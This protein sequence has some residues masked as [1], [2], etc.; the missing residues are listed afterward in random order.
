MYWREFLY[1]FVFY[2]LKKTTMAINKNK[3]PL[4]IQRRIDEI[5]SLIAPVDELPNI[6]Y[7]YVGTTWPFKIHIKKILVT[8]K[9]VTIVKGDY[10]TYLDAPKERFNANDEDYF[11]SNGIIVLKFTLSTILKAYKKALNEKTTNE[12]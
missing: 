9:F 8:G 5:N 1:T 7:S 4:A 10:D 11:S 2:K 6:P 3:I 12:D